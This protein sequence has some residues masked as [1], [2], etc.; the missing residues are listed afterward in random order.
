[1]DLLRFNADDIHELRIEL[2][3]RKKAMSKEESDR[4]FKNSVEAMRRAIRC[5]SFSLCGVFVLLYRLA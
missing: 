3:E 5:S 1:M 2:A 4:D